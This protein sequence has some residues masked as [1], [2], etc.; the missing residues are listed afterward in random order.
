M[1]SLR[2]LNSTGLIAQKQFYEICQA[3][4][5]II[6][7]EDN[8]DFS[9]ER[10]VN[11]VRGLI[12]YQGESRELVQ[13]FVRKALLEMAGA[14]HQGKKEHGRILGL[15]GEISGVYE[16]VIKRGTT[17]EDINLEKLLS[18]NEVFMDNQ[19][20]EKEFDAVSSNTVFEFKF[21]LTLQKLYQQVIGLESNRQLLPHLRVIKDNPRFSR[22]RNIVY[23]GESENGHFSKALTVFIRHRPQMLSKLTLSAKG[24][25]TVKFS[26]D[27][28]GEF[29]CAD[30]TLKFA[31]K[32]QENHG[33]RFLP[34]GE[35]LR[36]CKD[37]IEQ[38]IAE[39]KEIRPGEKFDI[40]VAISHSLPR[41][42]SALRRLFQDRP[43]DLAKVGLNG[44]VVPCIAGLSVFGLMATTA[45][46]A[47]SLS[48]VF[49]Y[50]GLGMVILAGTLIFIF[51]ALIKNSDN[52]KLADK[53]ANEIA[54]NGLIVRIEDLIKAQELFR[55]EDF[56]K[57]L[58]YD[59]SIPVTPLS[60]G[61]GTGGNRFN[62]EGSDIS[63]ITTA[64]EIRYEDAGAGG[65]LRYQVVTPPQKSGYKL[66]FL[67]RLTIIIKWFKVIK[68][69]VSR[70][71]IALLG[72]KSGLPK[73]TKVKKQK[74]KGREI[75]RGKWD[76]AKDVAVIGVNLNTAYRVAY[77]ATN[78]SF[79]TTN[80]TQT[81]QHNAIAEVAVSNQI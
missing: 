49:Y 74:E 38:I 67:D 34:E 43:M 5:K 58:S 18:L 42:T 9:F 61:S 20:L 31:K 40:I 8:G 29:L 4:D 45:S 14:V 26:L 46:H 19:G 65:A 44:N 30:T 72:K 17:L 57:I 7:F 69:I 32:E 24:G 12:L 68:I 79:G 64:E 48:T 37:S 22:I 81:T 53:K 80:I 60:R 63:K 56:Y 25:I 54:Q 27:E 75:E 41:H 50:V 21:H 1:N 55:S 13:K 16:I 52:F 39:F 51:S 78:T 36:F 59:Y 73:K 2:E 71:R 77:I 47:G 28:M 10:L 6:E 35:D 33:I 66:S 76:S 23:F 11:K 70:K 3:L 15:A 62:Q